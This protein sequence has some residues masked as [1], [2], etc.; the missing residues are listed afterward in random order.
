MTPR[1]TCK[2]C[3]WA[4]RSW[5]QAALKQADPELRKMFLRVAEN[6]R[7]GPCH[8]AE[9]RAQQRAFARRRLARRVKVR[10]A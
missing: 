4:M 9:F 1:A 6:F 10:A 2:D 7:D 8:H 5:A 3:R